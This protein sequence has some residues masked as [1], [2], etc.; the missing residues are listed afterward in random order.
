MIPI[1]IANNLYLSVGTLQI[2]TYLLYIYAYNL[3]F[4]IEIVLWCSGFGTCKYNLKLA[5]FLQMDENLMNECKYTWLD[6]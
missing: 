3:N 5:V 1:F 6:R 4:R 2:C